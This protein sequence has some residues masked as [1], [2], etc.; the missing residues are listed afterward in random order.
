MLD[1]LC[2]TGDISQLLVITYKETI[3][4][5][6]IKNHISIFYSGCVSIISQCLV[7]KFKF[8]CQVAYVLPKTNDN[9]LRY[10]SFDKKYEQSC[11]QTTFGISFI[12]F[13]NI[14]I[15][16]N[17]LLTVKI[18]WTHILMSLQDVHVNDPGLALRIWTHRQVT[19]LKGH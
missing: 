12:E 9:S 13:L 5:K 16:K 10:Y 2:C 14:L 19:T 18:C 6:A 7:V 4:T 11:L 15:D 1:L 3:T 17:R 8:Y